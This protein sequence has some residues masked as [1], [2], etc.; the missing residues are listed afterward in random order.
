MLS[1]LPSWVSSPGAELWDG[2]QPSRRAAAVGAAAGI[3][4]LGEGARAEVHP[5]PTFSLLDSLGGKKL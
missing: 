2:D 5:S 1:T 3:P 4:W